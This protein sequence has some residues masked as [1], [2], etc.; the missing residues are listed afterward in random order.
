M[1]TYISSKYVRGKTLGK[2]ATSQVIEC[3]KK[4]TGKKF[5]L[6]ILP[7]AMGMNHLAFNNEKHILQLLDHP[8]IL[9]MWE[10]HTDSWNYY[11]FTDLCEGGELFER[12]VDKSNPMTAK[13]ASELVRTML[14]AIQH[15][16][17]K[18]VVH[19]DLKPENFVFKSAARDGKMVLIDF[20]CALIVEDTVPYDDIVGTPYYLAPESA[21][22]ERYV[23]T[24]DVLKSSDVWSIGII[25]YIMLT[26]RP[27]FNGNSNTE[28]YQ[29]IVNSTLKFP[30]GIE[31]SESF[32]DFCW[33]M[34][35]KSPKRRIKVSEALAHK[36][37]QGKGKSCEVSDEVIQVLRQFNKQS[38]LKKAVT[39]SLA[40]NMSRA[41]QDKVREQFTRL[42]QNGDQA[43][44]VSELSYMFMDMGFS[45][46]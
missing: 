7:T 19:R 22:G 27:P 39:K 9:K 31:L 23:R 13:L 30:T 2:G 43:L 6:K 29:Q 44:D 17:E 21:V 15:C 1:D 37:I 38:K 25:A 35:Q 8:N 18:Q 40:R 26:G 45:K 33:L 10:E 28:M 4:E 34:L 41:T 42:D 46:N 24:G 3:T 14:L 11:I 32:K 5:A 20:G 16:H 12:L 36:W